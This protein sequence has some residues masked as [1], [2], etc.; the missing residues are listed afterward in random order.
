MSQLRELLDREAR[1]VDAAPDALDTVLRKHRRGRVARRTGTA[2]LALILSLAAI[3]ILIEAIGS[4]G[5]GPGDQSPEPSRSAP[6]AHRNGPIAVD[7][8]GRLYEIDPITG[9][10]GTP[11]I[12]RAAMDS[13]FELAWTPDGRWLA[14]FQDGEIRVYDAVAGGSRTI[15]PYCAACGV[16]ISPDGSTVAISRGDEITLW[17]IDG[18]SRALTPGATNIYSPAWSPD[19][20]LIAFVAHGTSPGESSLDVVRPDGSG[21]RTLMSAGKDESIFDPSWSPDGVSIAFLSVMPPSNEQP[22]ERRIDVV[23]S[24]VSGGVSTRIT[25]VGTC[26]CIASSP[27]MAW[28]PDG[29]KFAVLV[30]GELTIVNTD[31]SGGRLLTRGAGGDPVWRPFP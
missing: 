17:S 22:P 11:A 30:T 7:F 15:A 20:S 1:R 31:G 9:A 24:P 6:V 26:S 2:M 23:I 4:T 13:S 16:A 28:S 5:P 12:G 10:R 14:Y 3:P 21:F 25:G 19:G 18:S 29:T 27:R 8:N